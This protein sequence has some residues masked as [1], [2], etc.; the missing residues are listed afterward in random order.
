MLVCSRFCVKTRSTAVRDPRDPETNI[1]ITT[2]MSTDAGYI[3][4]HAGGGL[5]LLAAIPRRRGRH[6]GQ[7]SRGSQ[8]SVAD[9]RRDRSLD[10]AGNPAHPENRVAEGYAARRPARGTTGQATRQDDPLV[11]AAPGPADGDR[12]ECG[13]A[14]PAAR[15]LSDAEYCLLPNHFHLVLRPHG[16]GDLGRCTS[17]STSRSQAAT[18]SE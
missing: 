9:H 10:P 7:G 3:H 14:R 16:D 6:S 8:K 12:F 18:C 13:A 11:R 4:L 1:P 17:V 15:V 5:A 2:L